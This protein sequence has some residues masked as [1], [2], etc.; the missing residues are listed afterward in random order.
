MLN[1]T[2][3]RKYRCKY[4]LPITYPPE[5]RGLPEWVKG[6]LLILKF[7]VFFAETL[8]T[9]CGVYEFLFAGEKR[10]AFRTDFHADIRFRGTDLKHISTRAFYGCYGILRMNIRFHVL[11]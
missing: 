6:S 7:F 9:T 11:F 5:Q 1:V 8:D 10:M 4:K 2:L 3:K